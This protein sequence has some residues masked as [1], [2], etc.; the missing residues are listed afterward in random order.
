MNVQRLCLVAALAATVSMTVVACNGGGESG[1]P[2]TP[3]VPDSGMPDSGMPDSG[4]SQPDTPEASIQP[5]STPMATPAAPPSASP[6]PSTTP[7]LKST[8]RTVS[9]AVRLNGKKIPPGSYL[10]FDSTF[11][12]SGAGAAAFQMQRS[13]VTVAGH[14][15]A[16]P[17]GIVVIS[18]AAKTAT[19]NPTNSNAIVSTFPSSMA[20]K[21]F[22]DGLVVYLP[23]G[24]PAHQLLTW[25]AHFVSSS[26]ATNAAKIRWQSTA[27]A[28]SRF[29]ASYRSLRIDSAGRPQNFAKSLIPGTRSAESTQ[30]VTIAP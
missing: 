24:L 16:G 5:S 19:I 15:Y 3:G 9:V 11:R 28:Y 21:L 14:R 6:S 13:Q 25:T 7:N 27:A 26:P 29:S 1:I 10:W 22:V 18:P 12:S 4:M 20:G 17:T 30:T 23:S 8:A 2:V